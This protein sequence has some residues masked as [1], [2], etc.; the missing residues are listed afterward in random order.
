MLNVLHRHISQHRRAVHHCTIIFCSLFDSPEERKENFHN[1]NNS[2]SAEDYY[3]KS[4]HDNSN[5]E[6]DPDDEDA[7]SFN[8]TRNKNVPSFFDAEIILLHPDYHLVDAY[9]TLYSIAT[10]IP[11]S[12]ASAER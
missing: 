9:P 5:H 12:F 3:D 11:I 7:C 2:N 4:N 10:A 1:V 6:E 8:A